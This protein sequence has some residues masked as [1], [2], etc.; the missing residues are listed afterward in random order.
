MAARFVTVYAPASVG[1][2][3]S[4]SPFAKAVSDYAH[5][6]LVGTS[7]RQLDDVAL[8]RMADLTILGQLIAQATDDAPKRRGSRRRDDVAEGFRRGLRRLIRGRS[9][10]AD[11]RGPAEPAATNIALVARLVD[12][13]AAQAAVL[14]FVLAMTQ[15]PELA[16]FADV[17][18]GAPVAAATVAVGAATQ[19][20]E[21]TVRAA[22][23]PGSRL[24]LSGLV[25]LDEDVGTSVSHVLRPAAGL[26]DAVLTPGL[27]RETLISRYLPR[28]DPS[29]LTLDNFAH[30]R[31]GVTA[32]GEILAAAV[33]TRRAGVN[34]LFYG[35][36][37]TGKSELAR[38]LAR[39]AGATLYVTGRTDPH[40]GRP[41]SADRLGSLQFG[42][43]LLGT[44]ESVL[45]FDELED[46]F[47]WERNSIF[48]DEVRA[49]ARMSKQWY[50]HMLES[51]PIP[52]IWIS[53]RVDG[54]DPAFLRRF[55]F[56]LEFAP[57]GRRQRA[58]VLARHLG[59]GT[60]LTTDDVDA[61]AQRFETSPAQFAS[62]VSVAGLLAPDGTPSR[63]HLE[64]VLAPMEKLLSGADPSRRPIFDT[65]SYRLD[66]LNS[67]A[68][69]LGIA[70]QLTQWKP[71][72]APGVSLCLYGPPGTGKSEYVK[73]LAH[74]M[75]RPVVYRRASDL[76]SKWLG[77]SERQIAEAFRAAE[78]DDAV[79]LFDEVDSFLRDRR[80]ATHS[81]EVTQVNEFLQQ[82]ESFQGIV[83]CTTNLWQGLDEASLRRFVFKIEFRHATTEQA[84]TLFRSVFDPL[85][86]SPLGDAD[87]REVRAALGRLNSLAP[88]DFAAVSRRTRALGQRPSAS[89]LVDALADEVRV[90]RGATRPIGF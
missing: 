63:H 9:K 56:A 88:G 60:A 86:A 37:G 2:S 82:L 87:E 80:G 79:L 20:P 76:L 69:L 78:R 5:N 27:D 28:A 45:L 30:L 89:E 73:F 3:L 74:C 17:I 41:S 4:A 18:T 67:P 52:T 7:L 14:Q 38:L 19:L 10:P 71:G 39:Q 23:A 6:L 68:D 13:D 62:A 54:V 66:A 33:R 46:V 32:A 26:L 55:A 84:M 40:G 35:P 47:E 75:G 22:I 16:E 64:T 1:M 72:A 77:Q 70:E 49:T 34:V 24:V 8:E 90:K 42:Q 61:I 48:G 85:L 51:N 83:A 25:A 36:T 21:A 44:G 15:S 11:P 29:T 58:R 31:D 59:A 43:R 65:R 53:N 81:W 57:A 50:T 12:L